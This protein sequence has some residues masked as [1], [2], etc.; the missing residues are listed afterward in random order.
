MSPALNELLRA[1]SRS[2]WLTL[3]VLPG[4]IRLQIG[5]AYL[6][7]RTTDTIA[8]TEIIPLEQ[9]LDA[10]HKLRGRILGSNN[11]PLNFGELAKQQG[12]PAEKLLLEK[13]EDNLAALQK[14]STADQKLIREVLATITSGQEL[15]LRRFANAS[16]EQIVALQTASELDDYTYRVAGCVGEFWTKM[17]R[18]H[19][20]LKKRLDEEEFINDGIRFGKGLQLVNILRDLPADLKKG[21]CYLP[22]EKLEP[23]GLWPEILFSPATGTKF[24]SLYRR[25]LDD[26]QARLESGW[27]YTNTLPFWQIR[28]RLACA[29]PIL[30]GAK[31]VAKLRMADL[32]GLRA[33]IKVSRGEVYWILLGSILTYPLPFVWRKLFPAR[34]KAVASEA[35]LA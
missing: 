2:F 30:I 10:L 18:A 17:C 12:L 27:R 32:N 34:W 29:W 13:V 9:R 7:A 11:T 4:A 15:D 23:A 16:A 14:F 8:D 20:F 1:T 33:R 28:V 25:Y 19:L 24:L 22:L 26:A 3:R 5:L 31:T 35:N 6:L 21:R